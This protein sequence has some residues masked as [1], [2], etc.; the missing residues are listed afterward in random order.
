MTAGRRPEW[1][2]VAPCGNNPINDGWKQSNTSSSNSEL[3]AGQRLWLRQAALICEDFSVSR[4]S[5][6]KK[7]KNAFQIS[8]L[9]MFYFL[10]GLSLFVFLQILLSTNLRFICIYCTL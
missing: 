5:R 1:H 3:D 2:Y 4:C 8:K 10:F 7:L 9:D 6:N